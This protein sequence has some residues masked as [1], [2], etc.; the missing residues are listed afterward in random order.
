[1]HNYNLQT[2]PYPTVSKSFMYSNVFMAKSGAQPDVQKRDEQ[3]DRQKLNIFGHI[4][5]G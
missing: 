2:F 3:T 1:M 5:G 4:G